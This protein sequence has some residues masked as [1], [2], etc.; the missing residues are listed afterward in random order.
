MVGGGL[1]GLWTALRAKERNPGLDVVLI[2]GDRIGNA[3]SGRNGGFVAASITHGHGNGIQRWPQEFAELHRLGLA[4]FA[5]IEATIERYGIDCFY[6]RPGDLW[7]ATDEYQ[8]DHLRHGVAEGRQYGVDLEFLDQE[9]TRSLIDSPTY[10]AAV[11][12]PDVG[13]VDPARLCWGLAAAAESLGVR[14]FEH[15]PYWVSTS[16][17]STWWCAPTR[18]V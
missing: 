8:I 13:L 17:A 6:E 7:V 15:S 1:T 14:V 10:L 3:A 4:N 18:A 5:E 9:A 16:R 11:R 2:E 12:D